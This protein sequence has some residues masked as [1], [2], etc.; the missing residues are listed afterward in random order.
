[1]VAQGRF[2][3]DLEME[4]KS[5]V[6]VISP[7]MAAR[8]F[9]AQQALGSTVRVGSAYYRVIGIMEPRGKGA[10]LDETTEGGQP[11]AAVERM[12]I[13]LETA[14]TRYGEVLQK[15]RRGSF[16]AERVQLHEVTVKVA[17][18]EEVIG[19]SLAIKDLMERNH[20]KKD[21]DM[22]VPLELLKRAERTKQIFNIVL[23]SIAAISLLVGGIGIMNIMLAS[24]TERTREIGIRRALGAR[25]RD[26]IIQFLV[27]TIM[28]SGSGGLLGVALGMA[29]PFLVSYF[30]GMITIVTF[31][32]PLVAFSISGLVGVIFGLYPA[33]RAANMD[34]VEALRHE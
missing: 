17:T 15:L 12:F 4:E 19:V 11:G 28:L 26:I 34:P 33:I 8:L 30:A 27:E 29:I 24:V 1:R 9:P 14:K 22:V 23:G 5:S 25:R 6:C 31:W 21:Y 16:E 32:S 3:T 10:K 20:K 7:E 2:F 18:P 13:P